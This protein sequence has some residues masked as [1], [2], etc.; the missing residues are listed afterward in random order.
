MVISLF[1]WALI[2]TIYGFNLLRSLPKIIETCQYLQFLVSFL[3]ILRSNALTSIDSIKKS[4][5]IHRN[6]FTL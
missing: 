3:L 5:L 1:L 2:N 6:K 4:S